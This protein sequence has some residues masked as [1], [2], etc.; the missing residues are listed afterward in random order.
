[1][2]RLPE[3]GNNASSCWLQ[4]AQ[5]IVIKADARKQARLFRKKADAEA[6]RLVKA[7]L[8]NYPHMLTYRYIDQ[9]SADRAVMIIKNGKSSVVLP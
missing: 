9:L 8:T 5:P 3:D 2:K 1:M 6:L 4:R 7:A